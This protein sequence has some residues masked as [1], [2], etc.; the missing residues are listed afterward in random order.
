MYL[1]DRANLL[2]YRLGKKGLEVFLKM[3]ENNEYSIPV[4]NPSK[5]IKNDFI[6]LESIDNEDN[7]AIK[8]YAV[9]ADWH[10]IPSLKS[11]IKQ[12]IEDVAGK[13]I[14]FIPNDDHLGSFVTIKEAFK[15]ILPS[16]YAYLKELKDII[17]ERNSVRDI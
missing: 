2:I 15:K 5:L 4:S 6:E 7:E 10:E 8:A 12:D 16:Q 3:G 17:K 13:I 1:F 9:E 11:F 14:D